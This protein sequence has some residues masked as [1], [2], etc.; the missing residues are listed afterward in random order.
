MKRREFLGQALA[1]GAAVAAVGAAASGCEGPKPRPREPGA[2]PALVGKRVRWRMASSFPRSLDTIYGG[3]E[4]LA[5]RVSAMT[6]GAFEIRVYPAGELVPAL[7]V[8]DAVQQG[9]IQ[10]GQSASYYYIGKNPALA[11]DTCVPFGMT[12]RQQAAWLLEGRRGG[13]RAAV[14]RLQR[15]ELPRGQHR[16]PD[17]GMVQARDRRS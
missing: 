8:L 11:F 17:G 16:G 5:E 7:Q 2:G 12:A 3:A 4:V 9:T 15:P 13:P 10:C 1:G 6:G 14:R